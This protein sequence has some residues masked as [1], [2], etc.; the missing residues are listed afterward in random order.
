MVDG[1]IGEGGLD[2]GFWDRLR[3]LIGTLERVAAGDVPSLLLGFAFEEGDVEAVSRCGGG[4]ITAGRS[5]ADDQDVVL[6]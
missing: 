2:L 6:E 5:R 4:R 1:S 3:E